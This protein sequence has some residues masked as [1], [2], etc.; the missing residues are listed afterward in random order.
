[1]TSVYTRMYLKIIAWLCICSNID[2]PLAHVVFARS[3]ILAEI[4]STR[5]RKL[6]EEIR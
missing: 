1:M 5:P 2:S 3:C 6:F 4:N